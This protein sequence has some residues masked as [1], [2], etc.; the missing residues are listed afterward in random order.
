MPLLWVRTTRYPVNAPTIKEKETLSNLILPTGS[1]SVAPFD[2]MSASQ[3]K[4]VTLE[5]EAHRLR[6]LLAALLA[7]TGP[8][9]VSSRFARALLAEQPRVVV[10][11]DATGAAVTLD[12]PGGCPS[13][14]FKLAIEGEAAVADVRGPA[15][16]RP[17][18][19]PAAECPG[20]LP[21]ATG[22]PASASAA[23]RPQNA[24]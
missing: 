2:H 16:P 19:Y 6:L 23:P 17:A 4:I 1:G 24:S 7:R 3:R 11:P 22:A 5:A 10:L 14:G 13:E 12:F 9:H 21:E 20:G 8:V 15:A 18:G